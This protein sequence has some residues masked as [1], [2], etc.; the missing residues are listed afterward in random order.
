M[1]SKAFLPLMLTLKKRMLF[2]PYIQLY[3]F[4]FKEGVTIKM[5]GGGEVSSAV[6]SALELGN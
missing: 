1:Y 6:S 2:M 5:S 3:F 4:P